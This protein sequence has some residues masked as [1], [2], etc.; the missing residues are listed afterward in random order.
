MANEPKT[1]TF[2]YHSIENGKMEPIR[3]EMSRKEPRIAA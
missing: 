3:L 1:P 2:L